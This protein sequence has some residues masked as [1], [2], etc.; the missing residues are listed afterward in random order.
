MKSIYVTV[1]SYEY[2]LLGI[3]LARALLSVG[4]QCAV[5]CIDE[6]GADIL[7]RTLPESCMIFGPKDYHDEKLEKIRSN[8]SDS[9]YCWTFKSVALELI[10]M[11]MPKLEW[12]V[13]LD[14]DMMIFGDP[15]KA[16]PTSSDAHVLLTP[17]RPSTPHF[18]GF[19][20]RAGHFNAGYVA[21][22]NSKDGLNALRW[23]REKCEES[24]SVTPDAKGYADQRYLNEFSE[25]FN[26]VVFSQNLGV[27]AAPWNIS[28]KT[29]T[30]KSDSVFVDT[31]ELLIYHMQGFKK[32]GLGF[33]D[34]YSG[35]LSLTAAAR[36]HIYK[37]Y[38]SHLERCLLLLPSHYVGSRM[39]SHS[40]SIRT[41]L[42]EIKR[43]F[44]GVS[45]I[46]LQRV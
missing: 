46:H 35:E 23:W 3:S 36:D 44:R 20:E 6:A 45:N 2:V 40:R 15:D 11:Q 4:K 24:C 41:V 19:M 22:R 42:R 21:F 38:I 12:A 18:E 13:Y 27:N 34:L 9:E 17:H 14:S 37:P 5:F 25:R 39:H 33:Y 7:K 29:I 26:G 28:G 31:D 16:L 32:I 10:L 30:E 1:I 8:R 43:Q